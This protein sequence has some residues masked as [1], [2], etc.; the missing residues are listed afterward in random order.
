MC[1]FNYTS[2]SQN[3]G[4]IL[5][6]ISFFSLFQVSFSSWVKYTQPPHSEL[7]ETGKYRD[8]RNIL[9][10]PSYMQSNIHTHP[11]DNGGVKLTP[12]RGGGGLVKLVL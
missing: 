4:G 1:V 3:S 11:Y 9:E 6:C 10:I 5:I 2:L 8:S 12:T 7:K